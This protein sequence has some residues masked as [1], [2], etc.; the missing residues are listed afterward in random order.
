[1]RLRRF[2]FDEEYVAAGV[3][4]LGIHVGSTEMKNENNDGNEKNPWIMTDFFEAL[5]Y[6][7]YI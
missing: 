7:E 3:S 5:I 1:M 4:V 2:L 6:L